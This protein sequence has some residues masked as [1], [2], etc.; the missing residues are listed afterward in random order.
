MSSFAPAPPA[1]DD[2][3]KTW[4]CDPANNDFQNNR[5]ECL[6]GLAWW[7]WLLLVLGSCCLGSLVCNLVY[8]ASQRG[9]TPCGL[10]RMFEAIFSAQSADPRQMRLRGRQPGRNPRSDLLEAQDCCCTFSL[11]VGICLIGTFDIARLTVHIF[12]AM[13]SIGDYLG[14][15]DTEMVPELRGIALDIMWWDNFFC[16]PKAGLWLLTMLTVVACEASTFLRLLLFRVP[17]EF[18]HSIVFAKSHMDIVRD[19]CV[20]DIRFYEGSGYYGF[21]KGYITRIP[22][23]PGTPLFRDAQGVPQACWWFHDQEVRLAAVHAL[24]FVR[25][26]ARV[27]S[28]ELGGLGCEVVGLCPH[29]CPSLTG[30]RTRAPQLWLA[31]GDVVLNFILS[32][33]IIYIGGSLLRRWSRDDEIAMSHKPIRV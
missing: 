17:L 32:V 14:A 18:V 33:Y 13:N 21:R 9:L 10:C 15:S 2:L 26:R 28:C 22:D 31:V 5:T 1:S 7:I 20:V 3:D 11:P 4:W 12:Y 19:L 16:I 24:W 6:Y 27:C 8:G 23:F 30:A 25:A 29:S